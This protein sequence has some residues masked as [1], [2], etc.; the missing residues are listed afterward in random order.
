VLC[1]LVF[2][3]ACVEMVSVSRMKMAPP[4]E[5][6]CPLKLVETDMT[7]LSPLGTRWDLLGIVSIGANHGVDPVSEKA[8][9][10]IRPKACELGGT[11]VSL[12]QSVSSRASIGMGTSG[13]V[14]FAVLRSKMSSS[15]APSDF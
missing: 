4:R 2:L 10:M 9:E 1:G 5:P 13:A 7:D 12:V 15:T 3:P 14:Q 11:A 8:R 6:H